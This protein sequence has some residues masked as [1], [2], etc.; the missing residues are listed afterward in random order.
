[1]PVCLPLA[2]RRM[3]ITLALA[4][5]LPSH[6]ADLPRLVHLEGQHALL[7]DG[8]PFVILGA[9]VHNSSNHPAALQ[10]IWPAVKDVN[11]NTVE[12][13]AAWEQ[14]EAEDYGAQAQAA[15]ERDV[16]TAVLARKKAPVPDAASGSW[17]VVYGDYADEYFH[18]WAIASYI[19]A[20][21][22]TAPA[23]CAST[24]TPTSSAAP[25]MANSSL[26]T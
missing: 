9:Q 7:V 18:A 21:R 24:T 3:S 16:P 11:A 23:G 12:V 14:V 26:A 19:A 15:F 25:A 6:A 1:M 22:T 8:E 10:K 13:P 4:A 2:L 5:A 17:R 20:P